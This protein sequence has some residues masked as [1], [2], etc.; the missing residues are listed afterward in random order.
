MCFHTVVAVE[1]LNKGLMVDTPTQTIVAVVCV[2][3]NL[4]F[5]VIVVHYAVQ[6]AFI[7]YCRIEFV[8]V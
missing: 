4:S 5:V 1:P 8:T 7:M 6:F 3:I 2:G